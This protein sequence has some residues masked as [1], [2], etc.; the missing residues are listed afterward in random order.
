MENIN[1]IEALISIL[2]ASFGGLVK[3]LT[4]KEKNPEATIS[5]SGYISS[6]IISSFIGMV[7]FFLCKNAKVSTYLMFG[8][9]ATSGFIGSSMLDLISNGVTKKVKDFFSQG[10]E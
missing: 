3:T 7:I 4:A 10:G 6:S 5:P 8:L 1:W 2:I 9:T